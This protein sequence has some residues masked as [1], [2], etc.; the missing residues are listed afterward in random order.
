MSVKVFYR[1]VDDTIFVQTAKRIFPSRSLQLGQVGLN[2][3][4]WWDGVR[5][6]GPMPFTQILKEDGSGFVLLTDC[7]N[8]LTM[9]FQRSRFDEEIGDV[10]QL[11]PTALF[12]STLNS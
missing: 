2:V 6:L 8:Y 4:F 3:E 5:I 7:V 1:E 10:S 11:N 9:T 12:L